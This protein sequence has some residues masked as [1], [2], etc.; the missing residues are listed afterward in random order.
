MASAQE[1]P[2]EWRKAVAF[3][4]LHCTPTPYR[5]LMAI[6]WLVACCR[7]LAARHGYVCT[8]IDRDCGLS[9]TLVVVSLCS[10][11]YTLYSPNSKVS[12]ICARDLPFSVMWSSLITARAG[13]LSNWHTSKCESR[14]TEPIQRASR[15]CLPSPPRGVVSP[16]NVN[17]GVQ[18]PY[19]G[20]RGSAYRPRREE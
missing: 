6:E 20:H 16:V 17:P 5:M 3:Y 15:V 10:V 4:D 19:K 2:Q 8:M 7:P 14:R 18:N 13:Q 11:S 12:Y 1:V 9:L